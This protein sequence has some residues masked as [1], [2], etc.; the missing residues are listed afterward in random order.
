MPVGDWAALFPMQ[1]P[2]NMPGNESE[3]DSSPW[4]PEPQSFI[5]KG[6]AHNIDR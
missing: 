6:K 4:D 5:Q 2:I 3:N 1:L